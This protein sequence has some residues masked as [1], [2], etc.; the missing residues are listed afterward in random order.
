M[1]ADAPEVEA[2][3]AGE[4]RRRGL[5]DLLRLGGGEDE[6]HARRRLLEDLE[7]R[8][9]RLAGQHVRFVH[10]IDLGAGLAAGRVHRPLAQVA[11]VVHPP[12]RRGIELHDV[13]VRGAV[14]DAAARVAFAVGLTGGCAPLAVQRHREDARRGRLP[15]AART[16]EQ[17]AVRHA[18]RRHGAPE[19]G[20]D[21]VLDDEVGELLGAVFAGQGNHWLESNRRAR[22]CGGLRC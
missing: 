7:E 9:P 18:A 6:H 3:E 19:R 1:R 17:V 10:D 14:P 20:R 16:G 8:V 5:R 22:S 12:V 21:V 4:N 15:H 11:R 2:L 13:E